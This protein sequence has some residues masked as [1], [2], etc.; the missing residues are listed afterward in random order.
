MAVIRGERRPR[1]LVFAYACEPG[2]GSEPGAGWGVVRALATFAACTVLVGSE[3]MPGIRR[4]QRESGSSD[5]EFVEVGRARAGRTRKPH[6]VTRFLFYM[7]WLHRARRVAARLHR[8]RPFDATWHVTY[9]AYWLPTPAAALNL[10]CVWGPVG[11]AVAAPRTLWRAL[12]WRGCLSEF[13]DYAA[14]RLFASLPATRRTWHTVVLRLMQNAETRA[15][16]PAAIRHSCLVLNHALL[17]RPPSARTWTPRNRYC[18]YVGAL[19]SRKGVWLV[20]HA[21]ARTPCDV[22]LRIVGDGPERKRLM[23]LARQL[24]IEAR[25][26]FL[27]HASRDAV[28]A[29]LAACAAAVYAGLREEGGL[30]LAEALLTGTPVVVLAHGGARTVAQ[31]A[32]DPRRVALVEPGALDRVCSDIADAMTRF[33]RHPPAPSG[34]ILSGEAATAALQEAL[35]TALES[36]EAWNIQRRT[37]TAPPAA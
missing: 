31:A 27:G 1:L 10:P 23:D 22:R 6:R 2:V 8:L 34:S 35:T 17:T 26:E 3:H 32:T 28:G 20:L 14:V 9:S 37:A 16:M 7:A 15:R 5:I 12:G 25:V 24:G 30:A 11:G 13:A 19:E 29:Q 36:R 21:L 4:W 18:L 33:V